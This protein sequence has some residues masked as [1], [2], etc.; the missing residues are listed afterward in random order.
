ML[1][2]RAGS[3]YHSRFG[4]KL[5]ARIVENNPRGREAIKS[6]GPHETSMSLCREFTTLE[7]GT[8]LR[9]RN[10]VQRLNEDGIA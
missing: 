8:F 4:R 10:S 6:T 2:A 5:A 9:S 1:D 7:T 3:L